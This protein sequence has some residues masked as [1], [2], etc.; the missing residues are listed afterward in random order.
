M[1]AV[2][3][4]VGCGRETDEKGLT[5]DEVVAINER[6]LE[7]ASVRDFVLHFGDN[8][9]TTGIIDTKRLNDKGQMINDNW[10]DLSGRKIVNGKLSNGKLSKG[11]YISKGVKV[12]IK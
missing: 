5:H 6:M 2:L 4:I 7:K 11:I 12:V 8:D 3:A 9:E 10:Y 1:F